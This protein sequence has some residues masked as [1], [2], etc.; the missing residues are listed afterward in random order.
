MHLEPTRY[1]KVPRLALPHDAHL[2]DPWQLLQIVCRST[3]IGCFELPHLAD[4]WD[5]APE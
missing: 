4:A 1:S 5:D 3:G 2:A